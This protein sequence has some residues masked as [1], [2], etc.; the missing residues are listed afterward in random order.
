MEN[1]FS[2]SPGDIRMVARFQHEIM[3]I[4]RSCVRE[5]NADTARS[6]GWYGH[7]DSLA[8]ELGPRDAKEREGAEEAGTALSDGASGSANL[9]A[10]NGGFIQGAQDDAQEA[11]DEHAS[12]SG[13][14]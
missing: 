8:K 3:Q 12:R 13:R 2:A 14:H 6:A 1:V 9:L 10:E 4:A 5:F 7:D 11:I